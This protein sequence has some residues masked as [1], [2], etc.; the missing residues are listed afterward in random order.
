LGG[1]DL[2]PHL[3][4]PRN[5]QACGRF[6]DWMTAA[7]DAPLSRVTNAVTGDQS[8]DIREHMEIVDYE[9]C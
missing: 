4:N 9:G 5:N 8:M 1:R 7:G 6:L 3:Q 2:V